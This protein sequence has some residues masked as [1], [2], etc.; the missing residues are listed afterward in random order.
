MI[1]TGYEKIE[2]HTKRFMYDLG[3]NH[4]TLCVYAAIYSFTMGERGLFHGSAAYL[5]DSIGL[6]VRTIRRAYSKLLSMGLI[7]R[8]TTEDGR[9]SGVRCVSPEETEKKKEET[10]QSVTS[11]EKSAEETP[12]TEQTN[13]ENAPSEEVQS[14]LKRI[15]ELCARFNKK[16]K[17][18][19]PSASES[20]KSE[21]PEEEHLA[22]SAPQHEKN[23]FIMMRKYE[24][25]GDNRKFLSFGKSGG[26][27]MTE[28]QYRR[29]LDLLPT[30][31]LMPYFVKLENM[32]SENLKNGRKPPHS[33]YRT[34]KKWIAED[35]A[36]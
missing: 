9:Y 19:F 25:P 2:Y 10:W 13:A 32:L 12:K 35:L 11:Q 21:E 14:H 3:I 28:A 29:L 33:H 34:L 31:E 17:K 1:A 18:G 30:E 15:D 22:Q 16:I 6:S 36:L 26:V 20:A 7:E 23:T 5:A 8:Y 24:K 4:S 27:I